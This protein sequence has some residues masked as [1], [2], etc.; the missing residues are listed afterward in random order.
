MKNILPQKINGKNGFRAFLATLCLGAFNDNVS[1]MV[2]I[3]YGTA[4]LGAESSQASTF[5][6]L[7]A[8]CFI[9]PYLLFS[10]FA[11]YLADRFRKKSVMIWSK[12]AEIVIMLI[13]FILAANGALYTLLA[14]LFFMGAQSAFFS[15]A[16][17][18]F[19]PETHDTKELS[20]ANGATQLWTFIAIIFGGLVG[21]LLSEMCGT[22]HLSAAFVFCVVIAIFGTIASVFITPTTVC[23]AKLSF[24]LKDPISPHYQTLKEISKDKLLFSAFIGNTLFWFLGTVAQLVLV[25]LVE[26]S[27]GGDKKLVGFLQAA[28]GLGIG[29]G[30]AIA[31][32][33]G[34]GRIPYHLVLPGGIAM[35]ASLLLM[36]LTGC[37]TATALAFAVLTGFFGGFYQLPLSTT[38]QERSPIAKRGQYLAAG[39]ALDC[40][41]MTAGSIMLWALR[42]M[43]IGPRGI[44]AVM[45][46]ILLAALPFITKRLPQ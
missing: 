40:I 6:S 28:L 27:I 24:Q 23:N 4:I 26:I 33:L 15:P 17:Y 43:Q 3:C 8:A 1:K 41:S 9:L 32:R 31:G 45:G 7:A 36:G 22:T 14:V 39:N 35:A 21:G 44:L 25:L 11:G 38:I 13:G 5:L 42:A 19:L 29:A 12:A 18:G 34:K 37:W 20:A 10:T 30:C 16:K 2:V 46:V